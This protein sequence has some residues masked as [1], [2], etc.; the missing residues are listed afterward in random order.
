MTPSSGDCSGDSQFWWLTIL[1]EV[2]GWSSTVLTP[3]ECGLFNGD[4]GA[5]CV[6]CRCGTVPIAMM[7]HGLLGG[8]QLPPSA[9]GTVYL[10]LPSPLPTLLLSKG[11]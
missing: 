5:S 10:W 7:A 4:F 2:N 9:Y 1:L 6:A 8:A 3:E 11:D